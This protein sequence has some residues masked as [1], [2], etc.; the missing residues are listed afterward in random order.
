VVS[1][2]VHGPTR[3]AERRAGELLAAMPTHP[4]GPAREIGDTLSPISDPPRLADLG[5]HKKQSGRWQAIARVPE[6]QLDAD[7]RGQ[8]RT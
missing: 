2:P 8:T 7:L 5:I 1:T 6:E 3:R 4:P